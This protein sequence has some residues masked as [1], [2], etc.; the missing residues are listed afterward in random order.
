M[1][2]KRISAM[3]ALI[4][5]LTMVFC[6]TACGGG[7]NDQDNTTTDTEETAQGGS[8]TPLNLTE[9]DWALADEGGAPV[10]CDMG[11]KD[12]AADWTMAGALEKLDYSD[13]GS[14]KD[15]LETRT[16]EALEKSGLTGFD[17]YTDYEEEE[18]SPE[19]AAEYGIDVGNILYTSG[20]EDED[21]DNRVVETGAYNEPGGDA[22]YQYVVYSTKSY[23]SPEDADAKELCEILT[24]AF[25]V[26]ADESLISDGFKAAYDRAA[27]YVLPEEL[28]VDEDT[29]DIDP[30][31][32]IISDEDEAEDTAES[33]EA[34]EEELSDE[35]IIEG[36]L[37]EVDLDEL[38]GSGGEDYSCA[39]QQTIEIKGEGYTDRVI[40]SISAQQ[41]SKDEIAGGAIVYASVERNRLYD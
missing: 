32:L 26:N 4:L 27:N 36:E 30:E 24:K 19:E 1:R 16:K 23:E 31:E 28:Q 18:V 22:Y 21:M 12:A 37:D 35:G 11:L 5:A 7:E 40:L 9:D 3:L 33:D 2:N 38:M 20:T 39:L 8:G 10:V 29:E 14:Q 25:G 34:A 6:F 17:L 41:V 13:L 15:A